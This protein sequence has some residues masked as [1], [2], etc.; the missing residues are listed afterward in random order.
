ME[1]PAHDFAQKTT[2]RPLAKAA[3]GRHAGNSERAGQRTVSTLLS[4]KKTHVC[5][6]KPVAEWYGESIDLFSVAFG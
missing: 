5:T 1:T 4:K 6:A 2:Q 3:I